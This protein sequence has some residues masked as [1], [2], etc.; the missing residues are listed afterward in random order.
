[1]FPKL[2]SVVVNGKRY[3]TD[4]AFLLASDAYWDGRNWE[5]KGR[6]I[7]LFKTMKGNYFA[8]YQSKRRG[9]QD[10]L[11]PLSQGEAIELFERLPKKEVEFSV[12]FP[13]VTIEDA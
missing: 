9:E 11:K 4:A 3:R 10:Y 2:M 12:A 7:F 1:M 13:D 6:N 5:R 8:Q